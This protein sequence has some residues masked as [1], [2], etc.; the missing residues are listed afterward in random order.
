MIRTGLLLSALIFIAPAARA[1]AV[2]VR[3]PGKTAAKYGYTVRMVEAGKKKLVFLELSPA[4]AKAFGHG[5]LTLTKGGQAVVEATV[6]IRKDAKGNGMLKLTIAPAAI[7][8]GE[9]TIWSAPIDGAPLVA[10]FGGFRLS[11]ADVLNDRGAVE[12]PLSRGGPTLT[13]RVVEQPASSNWNYDL[14]VTTDGVDQHFAIRNGQ[15]VTREDIRLVDVNGDGF[16]DIMV[17]GG[18][19]HRGE[20]W[21]K[22]MVYD[23]K[24]KKYGWITGSDTSADPQPS[25]TARP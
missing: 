4:A 13:V 25:P 1:D 24:G 7:D 14:H 18:K 10:N 5:E 16:L 21:F 9:F 19:D 2:L 6:T 3:L 12:A 22:T 8:G 15:P 11:I 23:S 20:A 17:V